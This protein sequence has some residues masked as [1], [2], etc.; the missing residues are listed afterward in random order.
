MKRLGKVTGGLVLAA[1]VGLFAA[2]EEVDYSD[3]V[4]QFISVTANGGANET[5][6]EL[7]LTFN[8]PVEG[9]NIADITLS[10]IP[11]VKV[12]F[13]EEPVS[14][15]DGYVYTLIVDGLSAAGT[16][17]VKVEKLGFKFEGSP[18]WTPLYYRVPVSYLSI[19]DN[20][21]PEQTTTQLF[22]TFDRVIPD[23]DND[24]ISLA[25]GPAGLKKGELSGPRGAG[26]VVYTLDINGLEAP[27][28]W[29]LVVSVAKDGY[30]FLPSSRQVSVDFY[31][32]AIN[33]MRVEAD[34][35]ATNKSSM[36]TLTFDKEI[37]GLRAG[38]I[39]LDGIPGIIKGALSG[40]FIEFGDYQYTLLIS[41]FTAGGP[42][43]VSVAKNGF[44][45]ANSTRSTTVY[46]A[47]SVLFS[48]LIANSVNGT[49]KSI[50]LYFDKPIAGLSAS[51]IDLDG[52]AGVIKGELTSAGN[53]YTLDIRG[54]TAGGLLS[55]A[56]SKT[57]YTVSGS[58][59]YVSIS[60]SDP[61]FDTIAEFQSWLNGMRTNTLDLP[62]KVTL[63]TLRDGALTVKQV[64]TAANSSNKYVRIELDPSFTG[65]IAEKAFENCITLVSIDLKGTRVGLEN[66]VF[67]GCANLSGVII[68]EG[69]T[70][71][72]DGVFSGCASLT[73]VIIGGGVTS[74]G[75]GV[76]FG[77]ARLMSVTI[78]AAVAS[79][80]DGVFAGC[81]SLE[82]INVDKDNE[83]YS[84]LDG[85][86]VDTG[87]LYDKEKLELIMF[88]VAKAGNPFYI[89]PSVETIREYAFA[90]CNKLESIIIP[91]SVTSIGVGAFKA[92]AA[93]KSVTIPNSLGK[94]DK[95][96]FLGCASLERVSF[97]DPAADPSKVK[98]IG[99]AAF[100]DC[101]I[102]NNVAI[103]AS[104]ETI[105]EGA[106]SSCSGLDSITI[107]VI[108][109]AGL[110]IKDK[111]FSGCGFSSVTLPVSVKSLG[112][113]VF[114]DCKS[115]TKIELGDGVET[116]DEYTLKGCD[117]LT[118]LII[119]SGVNTITA[120]ALSVCGKLARLSV[121]ASNGSY[122]ATGNVLYN[123]EGTA[124]LACPPSRAGTF[125]IPDSV[126]TIEAFAFKNCTSLSLSTINIPGTVEI[127]EPGAF[128]A[129]KSL[130]TITVGG[131][132]LT[133]TAHFYALNGVLYNFDR[134]ALIAYP[135]GK[136]DAFTIP[137]GSAPGAV[138][139]A[140]IWDYA[141]YAGNIGSVVIPDSVKAV[142]KLAFGECSKLVSVDFRGTIPVGAF[143]V[144][145]FP[146]DLRS[147]FYASITQSGTPGV[148]ERASGS[149][150]WSILY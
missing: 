56:V 55:V 110:N 35:D 67:S 28:P 3:V 113:E 70:S 42:L 29:Q 92:C 85:S 102:L 139:V 112:K 105:E 94:I 132:G 114:S 59:R 52:V 145:A 89:L 106:F 25:G 138:N 148:Y 75:D 16:V 115:L 88:P 87:V 11:V 38:D 14:A 72:G 78:G 69:V 100:K 124:L 116:I 133:E 96:V 60:Y 141:F 80:G 49:T 9:L 13:S 95:E 23:L 50:V 12:N 118:D 140:S 101:A 142:G 109:E 150:T 127:I 62:Y 32:P 71:I 98:T 126:T 39:S 76:F 86:G 46:Y 58:P 1:L 74:I 48:E 90:G 6:S 146:G 19:E 134:D 68:G 135:A 147:K 4:V 8:K 122:S 136:T 123:K 119:G 37:T 129:C 79:I 82:K 26:P 128:A 77:C 99:E 10:N 83:T 103:P 137:S 36:L 15:E 108:G 73:S 143:A 33:F 24:D 31:S 44:A 66:S 47:A 63:K 45:I 84:S 91:D 57:G 61:V 40:P 125:T 117:D 20:G 120:G 111:A 17:I 104:V 21:S 18:R 53:Q 41:D 7:Y 5:S 93:L 34:G 97:V 149:P 27:G 81:V 22:L 30:G 144:D 107:A 2:C 51:D 121:S 64:L 43:S 65:T 54:F 130:N 131:S